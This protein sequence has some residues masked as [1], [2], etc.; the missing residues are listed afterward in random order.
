MSL[1][2]L[3][4]TQTAARSASSSFA[5]T[6]SRSANLP[7]AAGNDLV[8]D[9]VGACEQDHLSRSSGIG[10]PA[11]FNQILLDKQVGMV[12]VAFFRN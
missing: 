2:L 8:D 12:L 3:T 5:P 10:A 1:L 6:G 7:K 4:L 11:P 9:G